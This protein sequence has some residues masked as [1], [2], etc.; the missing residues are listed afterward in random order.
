MVILSTSKEMLLFHDRV[1]E[2]LVELSLNEMEFYDL[3]LYCM[4]LLLLSTCLDL[5][6]DAFLTL[7]NVNSYIN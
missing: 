5:R 6:N 3:I 7:R 2:V 4:F 1:Y